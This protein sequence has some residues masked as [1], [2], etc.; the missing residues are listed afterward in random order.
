[1][2]LFECSRESS[3]E[4]FDAEETERLEY[5][6]PEVMPPLQLAYPLSDFFGKRSFRLLRPDCGSDG[7]SR[8]AF[9]VKARLRRDSIRPGSELSA[10]NSPGDP[11]AVQNIGQ[12]CLGPLENRKDES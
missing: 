5:F 9:L 1:M 2:V 12:A 7:I 11:G 6:S 10:D 8:E 3:V 4:Q